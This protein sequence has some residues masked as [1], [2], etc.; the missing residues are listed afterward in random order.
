MVQIVMSSENWISKDVF[1]LRNNKYFSNQMCELFFFVFGRTL[2]DGLSTVQMVKRKT[3]SAD[4]SRPQEP[5]VRRDR[6]E[7][8]APCGCCLTLSFC[9]PAYWHSLSDCILTVTDIL[10]HY[11]KTFWWREG[12]TLPVVCCGSAGCVITYSYCITSFFF[13]SSCVC[14]DTGTEPSGKET[15]L[16]VR[17]SQ[18]RWAIHAEYYDRPPQKTQTS[19]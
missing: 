7:R 12:D 14:I 6:E 10:R 8:R 19:S 11:G 16:R 5:S 15:L 1:S 18:T 3:I 9:S 4:P 13:I 17:L 2:I